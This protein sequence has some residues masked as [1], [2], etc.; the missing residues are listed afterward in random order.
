MFKI[1]YGNH[2]HN[3][4]VYS[5]LA[6]ILISS[7]FCHLEVSVANFIINI[8]EGVTNTSLSYYCNDNK[9]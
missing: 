2:K 5:K 1:L 4:Y 9:N 6:S 7:I 8:S 3:R